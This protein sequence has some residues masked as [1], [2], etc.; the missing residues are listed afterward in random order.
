[1]S[2]IASV[3]I[4]VAA[5]VQLMDSSTAVSPELAGE[6]AALKRAEADLMRLLHRKERL[7]RGRSLLKRLP[8]LKTQKSSMYE[9]VLQMGADRF[10]ELSGWS[11]SEF[12]GLLG[13][14]EP[15]LLLARN[16]YDEFTPFE[17]ASRRVRSHKHSP[18][19]RLF[20][21]LVW[22]RTYQPLRKFASQWRLHYSSCWAD[23]TWL[24]RELVKHPAL[25]SEIQWPDAQTRAQTRAALI[26]CRAL[27]AGFED[28][29]A[30]A[31][32]TKD[33]AETPADQEAF[34]MRS[35]AP[36]RASTDMLRAR[37]VC[38]S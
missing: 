25:V 38:C 23:F 24:R 28:A 4:A 34:G 30:L 5:F 35:Y 7:G 20:A 9:D 27:P 18:A 6:V 16:A 22:L 15:V 8:S 3:V 11:P 10:Q 29:V 2:T 37:L 36:T 26:A 14:V 21:F 32:G 13:D 12:D 19:E 31:D 1:M 17:N 33:C